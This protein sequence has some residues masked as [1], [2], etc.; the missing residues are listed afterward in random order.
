M[1]RRI[2]PQLPMRCSTASMTP[3]P[4]SS[5][6]PRLGPPRDDIRPGLRYLIVGDYV[7][8]YRLIDEDVEIVRV[9]HGRRDLFNL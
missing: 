4:G 8:L 6:I 2:I 7:V 3:V 5:S 1:W 9:V